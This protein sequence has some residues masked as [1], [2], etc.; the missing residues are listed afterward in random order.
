MAFPQTKWEG[1]QILLAEDN[2]INQDVACDMLTK[3]GYQC[4]VVAN[5][6]QA[7][8]ALRNAR[9]D[10]VL[11]DCHMPEMDGLEAT[12]IIRRYERNGELETGGAIPII[13]LT[14]NAMR[15][16]RDRC[17]ESGMTD[18]LSKPLDPVELVERIDAC[19]RELAEPCDPAARDRS[20]ASESAA[21]DGAGSPA[22]ALGSAD[23]VLDL[24][25]LLR[26]CSGDA[27]L[28]D[29]LFNKF[30]NQGADYVARIEESLGRDDT[31]KAADSAHAIKGAAA[32][33]SA[34]ALREVAARLE[35]AGRAGEL[36]R[37]RQCATQL[38]SEWDRLLEHLPA[39]KSR[40]RAGPK[41]R[42]Q[43]T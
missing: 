20:K 36:E 9:Y 4:V 38:R 43:P 22:R 41:R 12:R 23:E 42:N 40:L 30:Q 7:V 6:R 37:A 27:G 19:L 3:A 15:S 2:E 18:Y 34:E 11:M 33:L 16:D 25:A 39:L 28:A 29:R 26:R 32:N 14:A 8:D 13:A 35:A 17:L 31:D 1:A 24:D 21:G 5:G 10:A